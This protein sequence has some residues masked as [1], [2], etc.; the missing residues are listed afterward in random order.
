[1][2]QR[3]E[4]RVCTQRLTKKNIPKISNSILRATYALEI[5]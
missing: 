2:S 4:I 5:N 1:M 3:I